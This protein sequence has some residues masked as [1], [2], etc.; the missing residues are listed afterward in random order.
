MRVIDGLFTEHNIWLV[1][2]AALMCVTGAGVTMRLVRRAARSRAEPLR[3]AV[4]D[5]CLR[6]ILDL[7][8]ALHRHARLPPGRAG[9]L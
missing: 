3:L 9:D 4:P 5:R 8:D 2:I 6:R 7:D 1:L